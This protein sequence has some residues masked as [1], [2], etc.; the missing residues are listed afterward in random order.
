MQR[1][2]F[3]REF[4][5]EAVKLIRDRGVSCAQASQDLGVHQS[6]L[7]V[8]GDF[9]NFHSSLN[10]HLRDCCEYAKLAMT[11]S[12]SCTRLAHCRS[13]QRCTTRSCNN[14]ARPSSNYRTRETRTEPARRV[15]CRRH[16]PRGIKACER[17]YGAGRNLTKAKKTLP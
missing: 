5:L 1:W 17:H 12:F 14:A 6:Q 3:T 16:Y 2:K 11:G 15:R 4:K 7:N 13:K 10:R 9:L 8:L